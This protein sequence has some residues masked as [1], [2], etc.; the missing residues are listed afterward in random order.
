MKTVQN[1]DDVDAF[2]NCV[3]NQKR[4]ADARLVMD[5]MTR[6]TG[7]PAKMWGAAIIGFDRY[8]YKRRDGSEHSYMM[9]GLS[10][11]KAA[12][13]VYIMPGFKNYTEQLARLGKHKHSSSCLYITRLENVDFEVLE[14]IVTD[15]YQVMRNRYGG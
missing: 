4:A 5:M 6:V 12:L 13:T 10:P 9:V 15:S 14:E 3:E 11:R 1:D 2:L 7:L 8:T